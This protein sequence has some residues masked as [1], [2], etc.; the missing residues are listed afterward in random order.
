MVLTMTY[1]KIYLVTVFR[2]IFTFLDFT[3]ISIPDLGYSR[4]REI[5]KLRSSILQRCRLL[6]T[7]V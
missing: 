2:G 4:S 5:P 6:C 1:P 3:S 7:G